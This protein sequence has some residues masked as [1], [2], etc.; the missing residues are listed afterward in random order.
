VNISAPFI[1]RP[2]ATSLL[3]AAILMAGMAAYMFLPVAPLP[4]VDFPTISVSASLPGAS[5][6]TM[7]SSVATPLERRFGRIAGVAEITSTSVLGATSITLQ[8]DLDRDVDAAGRDVQ[9]AIAAAGGELPPSLPTRPTFRKVNPSDSPILIL[10]LKSDQVPL[11]EIFDDANTIFAEKISQIKGV[12]QVFVGGGQQPA[13]RIQVDPVALNGVGLGLEDVRKA[14]AATTSNQPKG[15][16]VGNAQ[17]LT[18]G[19]N[20]QLF[21]AEAFRS[22]VLTYQN[23]AAIRLGDVADVFD[24]VENNRVAAWVNGE[25]AILVII[26]RQPGANILETIDRIKAV[27]PVLVSSIPPAIKVEVASDRTQSIRASV[28]DV[29]HTLV[30][31]V[32]L[33][34]V[35]VFVF[36]R[37]LSATA[38]PSVAVPL[39]LVGTFGLMFLAGYSL[40]NLSLM[41][42][43]I[44]TGFVVDDAIVVTENIARFIE[45]GESPMQAA[46]KGAKQIGF[47][48]VSITVSLLAVFIPILLM[49]GIV[50][51]LFREFAVTLSMAIAVS[52]IVSLT[53]TPMMCSRLLRRPSES[54]G[55]LY[56]LSERMFDGMLRFYDRGLRWVLRHQLVTQLLTLGAIAATVALFIIVPKGLFPQQD[57]GL[58]TGF[59]DA[60]QDV[61]F[62]SMKARQEALNAVIAKDP[63][64]LFAIEFTGAGGNGGST[65]NTGTA[66]I[67]L[68]PKPPRKTNADDIINRLRP[69]LAKVEGVNLFLQS[70]QDVRVGGRIARTQ[71]QYTLEDANLDE[72]KTFAPRMVARLQKVPDLRDVAT[73]QQTNG[74]ELD[75]NIDRDTASRMGITAQAIDATLYDAFGQEFVATSFTQINQYHVV[76]EVKPQ[77]LQT[78]DALKYIYVGAGPTQ[79]PAQA[80]SAGA[81]GGAVASPVGGG[82]PPGSIASIQSSLQSAASSG[83][84]ASP[85]GGLTQSIR[86]G[87]FASPLVDQSSQSNLASQS[88][89]A[90]ATTQSTALANSPG[91]AAAGGPSTPPTPGAQV[92]NPFQNTQ[93]P[94]TTFASVSTATTSL[95]I[96]HQGQ[97][98]AVTISFNLAPGK[99]LS[100]A[101]EAI[102]K[103]EREIG[104]PASVHGDFQGTAQ[105][106]TSSLA[107]EPVLIMAAIFTIYIVLGVLYESYV[108]PITIL[109]TLPSAGVGALLALLVCHTE[110]SV[111][112]LIGI[113]LLMGIVKKNAI[114]MVDFAIEAERE[115]NLSRV[116]AIHQACLLRFR[117]I[118]MT[119]LAALL[120]GLPLA[121]GTGT[122]SEM[123]RPLG[124]TIVGGLIFSQMLTLYTTPVIYLALDRL[125]RAKSHR[126]RPEGD[127]MSLMAPTSVRTPK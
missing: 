107:S 49:G 11:S 97:F 37:T 43:T 102:H 120:G 39:S 92:V 45:L 87:A 110:F 18:I 101:I 56:L 6:E 60:P 114:M 126:I 36:L 28:S 34:V 7:A 79:S 13:V 122:G 116:D 127:A 16:L 91:L 65:G 68:K 78:P 66:F 82:G 14:V 123:R 80:V 70:V 10:S 61:S 21:R 59:S 55:K 5:P 38:I 8:F 71:Y 3:A 94:L 75:V 19:A 100:Q 51:R 106:F 40:D 31:S 48:I 89:Q 119:T 77:Y 96:N 23:G 41:A 4:K 24:D 58:I 30:L 63:D 47:T 81:G 113:I 12:G 103:V 69:K 74:L 2:I 112:A 111:I 83:G 44:S 46:L 57:T 90:G 109:S 105:A 35:V 50:G 125:S 84:A 64:I 17:T 98:P 32:F 88:A 104:V 115:Q 117:P 33:V 9:A 54:H 118:M 52:A 15:T 22:I 76:L 27:M 124:I 99:S 20:S 29:E 86:L 95:S 85:Q 73:D 26:R 72:L 108:H 1:H 67:Q 93:V 42:L 25:R 62:P 53:L 121:L